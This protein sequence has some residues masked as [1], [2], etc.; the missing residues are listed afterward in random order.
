MN[1]YRD[2]RFESRP[3]GFHP[4][5]GAEYSSRVQYYDFKASPELILSVLEDFNPWA[6][7]Q[8][9]Q[10]FFELVGWLNGP[11]SLLE[12]NDCA[13]GGPRPETDNRWEKAL[14][15]SGRIM[16]FYR[17]LV[18]NELIQNALQLNEAVL[19]YLSAL[20]PELTRQEASIGTSIVQT[21]YTGP[22]RDGYRLQVSFWAW[23]N[24]DDEAFENLNRL[25]RALLT[26][27]QDVSGDLGRAAHEPQS[28]LG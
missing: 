12:S 10:T 2:H 16:I 3:S 11:E 27:L 4:Y 21:R 26:C 14:I 25:F 6:S 8:A 18:L 1:A 17:S 23:G 7:Y 15:V 13:F 19:H 28:R 22:H 20:E 5:D 24:T 9:V